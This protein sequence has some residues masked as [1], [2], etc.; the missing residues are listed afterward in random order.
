MYTHESIALGRKIIDLLIQEDVSYRVAIDA[1]DA[2]EN[3]LAKE[4]KPVSTDLQQEVEEP[5]FTFAQSR[6]HLG[7]DDRLEVEQCRRFDYVAKIHIGL[8]REG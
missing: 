2:A 1:L 5:M 4:T 8:H 7:A 6:P 3:I